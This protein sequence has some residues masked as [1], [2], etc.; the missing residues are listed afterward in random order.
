VIYKA[1]WQGFLQLLFGSL[2]SGKAG[3]KMLGEKYK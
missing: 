1:G 2:F 3:K